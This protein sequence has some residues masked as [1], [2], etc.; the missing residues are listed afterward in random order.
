MAD[1]QT[2]AV[3]FDG[4]L[5]LFEQKGRPNGFTTW[6]AREFAAFLG[7]HDYRTF[8][9]VLNRAQQVLLS[10]EIEV[11]EH[12]KQE[13]ITDK[14]G[15]QVL[16]MRLSRFACYLSAINAD[17][18]KKQVARAQAYFARFSEECQRFMDDAEQI[19][20]V[21][22][23]DELSEH[24]KTLSGTAKKAGVTDY[25]LFHN[26]GYRGLYNMNLKEL[27]KVKSIP[28]ERSALDFM[29]K[30]ELA[31]NLFRITQTDAKIKQRGIRGQENL[32]KAAEDVGK[33][34]R[35][36]MFEISGQRPEQLAAHD[37]I[38]KVKIALKSSGEI[39]KSTTASE[40]TD[41]PAAQDYLLD[42]ED[43]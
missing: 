20:R 34:V 35:D 10:L 25:A 23:R 32:E 26:A 27:K 6:S 33:T 1:E 36:T 8:K 2:I 4:D 40:L 3:T 16:D 42:P 21:L 29:G 14:S 41:M 37:D 18:K 30:D 28:K 22:I 5:P 9:A 7:Y 13:T 17:P 38:K 39:V 15:K 11:G 24:E 12:F 43:E 19:E 31:A